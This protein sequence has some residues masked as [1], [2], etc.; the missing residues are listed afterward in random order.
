MWSVWGKYGLGGGFAGG[1]KGSSLGT[2]KPSIW[3]AP[4]GLGVSNGAA[5]GNAVVGGKVVEGGARSGQIPTAKAC[6]LARLVSQ[7]SLLA[8]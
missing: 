3:N 6:G 1:G 2:G 4:E 7:F 5:K 8:F